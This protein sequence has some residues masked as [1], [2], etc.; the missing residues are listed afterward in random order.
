MDYIGQREKEAV[1]RDSQK[2]YKKFIFHS[3]LPKIKNLLTRKPK[4]VFIAVIP[5]N[6]NMK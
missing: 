5:R 4:T 1:K 2:E 6:P 3:L